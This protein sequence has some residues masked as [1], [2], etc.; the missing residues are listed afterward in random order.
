MSRPFTILSALL[1]LAARVASAQTVL[2]LSG[3]D[4]R[5][6]ADVAGSGEQK[7]LFDVAPDGADWLPASVPGNIQADVEA[8]HR[9]PPLWYG[10]IN[11]DLYEVARKDWWYRKDFALPA[12]Y[13]GKRLT[14]VF[15]GVDERC[16]VWL[17]GQ[18]IGASAGMFR[19]FSFDV[20]S[21]AK[22]GETNRLAVQVARMPDELMPWMVNSDGPDI[23]YQKYWFLN[24]INRTRAILKDLKTPGNFSY[25][26]STNV[27]TLGIWK[28]VRLEATGPARIEWTR[29]GTALNG[30][31]SRA[32]VTAGL[33][34]DSLV[35]QPARAKFC[36]SGQGPDVVRE[37]DVKL[38]PGRNMVIA[39]LP[40]DR[41][42]LWWPN[43]QGSQ[44]LYTLR[45]EIRLANGT[46]SDAR[47]TRFGI[48]NLRWVHTEG[49]PA[50]FISRYQ[51]VINGR[52]V[53]TMGSGLILPEILP[54]CGLPHELQLLR[55]AQAV[56]MNF[57]RI[58]G[59][60][61]G[62]LFPEAWYDLADELG[63]MISHEFPIGNCSPET[64]P[65][66]LANLE[67][68]V[69][70]MLKQY[71]NHPSIVE[72]VGGN[73]MSW[74]STTRHPAL[75]LMQTLAAK[76]TDQI[77]RATCP[78]AGARHS[79]WDFDI[80]KSYAHYNNVETMRY[81]EF[82]SC[83]PSHEEVWYRDIP[84]QSQ[85]PLDSF[86]DPVLIHK[87][88]S[89]AVFAPDFWLVKPRTDWAFGP[90]R[91]LRSLIRGGQ[92]LGAEGL[93][94]AY[95]ALRRK[96]KRIGGFTNHCYSEPWPNA[97]GSYLV[98]HDGRPLMNY[99]FVKQGLA[100]IVLSLRY[101]SVMYAPEAGIHAELFLVSDAPGDAA[102]LRWQWLARNRTGKVLARG[103]GTAAIRPLEVKSLAAISLKPD[104]DVGGPVLVEMRLCDASG[105]PLTERVQVFG[106]AGRAP[107]A[108]LLYNRDPETSPPV[109]ELPDCPSNLAYIGNGAKPATATSSY[110]AAK[111]QANHLNDGRY[112]NEQ[113]WIPGGPGA[114]FQIDLG[115]V[116]TVARFKL[117]RD[118]TGELADREMTSLKIETSA[119]GHDWQTV[120]QRGGLA[121]LAGAG[122]FKTLVVEIA[123][124]QARYVRA[125]VK[126]DSEPAA[127]VD[128]FEVYGPGQNTA[129]Q[130]PQ[131][132]FEQPP[133]PPIKPVRRTT[134]TVTAGPSH[135]DGDWETLD[136]A[137][138]NTGP[139]TALFCEPH[140]LLVYRTD[141]LIANNNC[142]IPPGESR[143]VTIRAPR[144]AVG[145]LTLNQ[146][147]WWISCWNADDVTIE[148]SGDVLLSVG[149]RDKM[150]REFAGYFKANAGSPTVLTGNRPDTAH[151]P[152]WLDADEAARFEFNGTTGP[153][154]LR[155][156]T[157]DQAVETPTE[158]EI[159]LNGRTVTKTLPKGLGIQRTDAA[160][161]AFPASVEC[162]W[163]ASALQT[164]KNTLTIRV[165]GAGWFT[166]DALDLVK[167]RE[168]DAR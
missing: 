85:W 54:G 106:P 83:S 80:R 84:I 167:R 163:P 114:S 128:E 146:T 156:H 11:P 105:E 8:A 150:C 104:A 158:V 118:R 131:V 138:K 67:A 51:L 107:L 76:E 41:P 126:P 26:W 14:L 96:G 25:D 162:E 90:A 132:R 141:L 94:Y 1:L 87:N 3:S 36:I 50:D 79:P 119:D 15:D 6:C 37:V 101:D 165:K 109:V 21:V 33:E 44:P 35:D 95:D 139:M 112:G 55:Q 39:E 122:P 59:G 164:G 45:A 153:A 23:P 34:V 78:D 140:P 100:P 151:L 134:L 120:F 145:G 56:G 13:A 89:R 155:I 7:R 66:F 93:R 148:P 53:R 4:W 72:F 113:S 65:L 32:V 123:P 40:V 110:P 29:V 154:R 49:A 63:I 149:R 160:H 18:K 157:A 166:W 10:A 38:E 5:I 125:S 103:A 57:L 60:G 43:G 61:G 116:A 42:A 9:L 168:P 86:D 88:A 2:S 46:V 70:S 73:E 97:A 111:H 62:A 92:Y 142:F 71:R 31:F 81:G 58:N 102:G 143:V 99:D 135:A 69:R 74:N 75:Q 17:N 28:D 115:K 52:P 68:T 137:V 64:N 91:D 147:G 129:R 130:L 144:Q 30:T 48:R 152:Y 117:G 108:G 98:D 159:T 24:G 19:R 127:C 16:K 47:I 161:L 136:L 22:P 20:S 124:V 121:S 12:D 133:L 27:W 82:G 77:F